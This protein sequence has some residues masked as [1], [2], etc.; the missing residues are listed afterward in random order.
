MK[1]NLY[2]K[3]SI[4][5]ALLCLSLSSQAQ[6]MKYHRISATIEPQKLEYLF[7][8]GLEVDHF[9]YEQKKYFTAEV[10]DEEIALFKKNKVKF[11]YI[12]EDLEENL[13]KYNA[14]IDKKATKNAKVSVTT[15]ANFALGSYAGFYT[16]AELQTILDQMR[17]LYPNLISA[18]SSIGTSIEGRPIFMVKISDNPDADEAEPE[19]FWNAVHHAREPMSMSQLIF[20]MWH[21]L[22]NYN[23][24]NDIKTLLNSTEIYIVPCVNP[25]GYVYNQTT[26]PNGGG[27]WRKNRKN[28]G[29]G[30]YGVDINRN[31]GFQ[32]G[33]DNTGSS[34]TTSSDTYRGPSAFSEPETQAVRNFCNAHTFTLSM[35]FH[36]YGNYCI[37]PYGYTTTNPN[38]EL[39]TFQQMGAFF[40]AENAYVHGSAVQT[41]NYTANGAG[42]DWKYGEQTTKPKIY[43]FTPEIGASTDGFWPASS[44]IIPLCNSTIEMNKKALKVATFFAKVTPATTTTLSTTS[45]TVAYSIQNFSVKPTT[46]TVSLSSAS[47]YVTSVGSPKTYTNPTLLQSQADNIAFT[48]SPSTPLGTQIQFNITVDNGLSPQTETVTITYDCL[49]PSS[50]TTTAISTT[51]A[52]LNW[53]AV[54]GASGYRISYK[55]SSSSTWSSEVSSLTNNYSLS[56][57]T[58]NTTYNWRVRTDSCNNY[59]QSA[60]FTTQPLCA[61]PSSLTTTS[62]TSTSATLGWGAVSGVLNYTVEYKLSTATTWIT[63]ASATTSTSLSLTGLASSTAYN[64]RV[65]ANCSAGGSAYASASF[66]TNSSIT[67][68]ASNGQNTS[69]MWIDYVN[70]GTIN[71]TSAATAGGYYNGTAISTNLV[72]GTSNAFR[73]SP[74][75]ASTV[76]RM[77][78]RVWIDYNKNGVFTDAGEQIIS[79]STTGSGTYTVNFTVPTS[80][81]L[82]NTRM[83]VSAKYSSSP[84]SC[85]SFTYGEVEDYTVN[86]TTATSNKGIATASLRLI[87]DENE[88]LEE[89][90]WDLETDADALLARESTKE[91]IEV[92]AYP[93]PVMDRILVR[94]NTLSNQPRKI[95]ILNLQ[96]GEIM[97]K[98]L[99]GGQSEVN[100]DTKDLMEGSYYIQ[101][102]DANRRKT[103]KIVKE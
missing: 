59:S 13:A 89:G 69:I 27:M 26:N 35:D 76:Y 74:G 24:D 102:Q 90:N 97:S 33:Y 28:N 18:K 70:L 60:T 95:K 50:L 68:C 62:I 84:T 16:F 100:F 41:V 30:T 34:P 31:Y 57:L 52:T 36:S 93:N 96:G 94:V 15:P 67:Y 88:G 39:S 14:E 6:R 73:F 53:G 11:E 54:A 48:I 47:S 64:W 1:S 23:T 99:S 83:R 45:G 66:T 51:G 87:S 92:D 25:D 63:A 77:Y 91:E 3:F 55:E 65:R 79:V 32:W 42:D 80:A 98:E 20:T 85:Q 58:A 29:N 103:I 7:N 49:A 40:T 56:G 78:W 75:F 43:S 21:L 46:Y 4:V 19:M 38:P 86:I 10:S 71:Q 22:E 5:I 37:Y 9:G 12:I 2:Y 61:T 72:R 101:L 81:A 82:G 17:T 44:R 8:N